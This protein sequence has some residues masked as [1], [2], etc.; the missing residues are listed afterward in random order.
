MGET[1]KKEERLLEVAVEAPCP[2]EGVLSKE[3]E[4]RNEP[5]KV[6]KG[7]EDKQEENGG[8]GEP[9][10]HIVI[11]ILMPPSRS[12]SNCRLGFI[13]K[14]SDYFS[15]ERKD[16]SCSPSGRRLPA[17]CPLVK[18]PYASSFPDL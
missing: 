16:D 14:D 13:S 8:P 6:E 10:E 1:V 9:R 2:A 3:L 7:T 11:P 17:F 18:W 5:A 4:R 12:T 15:D